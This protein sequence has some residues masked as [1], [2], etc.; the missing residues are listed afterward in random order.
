MTVLVPAEINPKYVA[1][2]LSFDERVEQLCHYMDV[3]KVDHANVEAVLTRPESENSTWYVKEWMPGSNIVT[4]DGD[5]YYSIK[6]VGGSPATDENFAASVCTLANPGS[7]TAQ[8]KGD[9]YNQFNAG[10]TAA[11]TASQK[12]IS[13]T[14]PRRDGATD[15]ADNTGGGSGASSDIV[16]YKYS[17]TTGDFNATGIKN[18]ALYEDTTP[19]AA[20]KL[21]THFGVTTFTKDS[22]STLKVF[23]NH[24]FNGT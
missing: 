16:S 17:W 2:A 15:D 20:T 18:G 12:A 14:Y 9:T 8:A 4:N 5:T 11:I 22:S 21:L 6:A 23:V 1:P 19:V 3:H 24:T 10:G 7:Q 13:G